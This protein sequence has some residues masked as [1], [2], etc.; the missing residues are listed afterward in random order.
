MQRDKKTFII[1]RSV[2]HAYRA[3]DILDKHGIRGYIERVPENL[4]KE[5]CGY[6]IAL[7]RNA[8]QAER[9]LEQYGIEIKRVL[10]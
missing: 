2:T 10:R 6:G 4:R 3:R 7:Y 1:L 5:G 9:I 8:E